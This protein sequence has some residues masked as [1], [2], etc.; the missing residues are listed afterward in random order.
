[1]A[2]LAMSE[3]GVNAQMIKPGHYLITWLAWISTGCG[4]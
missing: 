3:G 2:M 1:M 4:T